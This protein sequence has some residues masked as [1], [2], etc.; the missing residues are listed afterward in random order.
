VLS[1]AQV[2]TNRAGTPDVSDTDV[3]ASAE[4]VTARPGRI[5]TIVF[6]SYFVIISSIAAVAIIIGTTFFSTT[7][8]T[9][10]HDARHLQYGFPFRWVTQDQSALLQRPALPTTTSVA[11]PM[12]NPTGA[13]PAHLADD[14]LILGFGPP[15]LI[16]AG[17]GLVN[18][19][20][21]SRPSRL[22]RVAQQ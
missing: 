18:I 6:F 1:Y 3:V 19:T 22:I 11:S 15:A 8:V 5:P 10:T 7:R 13:D 12:E 16:A 4:P 14:F 21:R 2:L 9:T 20:R 17:V